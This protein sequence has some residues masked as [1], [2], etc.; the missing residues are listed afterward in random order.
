MKW[1]RHVESMG[2]RRGVYW[3]VAGNLERKKTLGIPR[4]R[5]E[6]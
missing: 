3:V 4:R 6:G 2:G 1:A 5:F